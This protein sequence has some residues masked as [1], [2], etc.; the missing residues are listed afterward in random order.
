MQ[1]S[2]KRCI[3][4]TGTPINNNL[5]ELLA[6]LQFLMPEFFEGEGLEELHESCLR[7]HK[8]GSVSQDATAAGLVE[9]IR[10]LMSPFVLRRRKAD[11]LGE[12]V[13][14]VD[15]VHMIDIS[16]GQRAIYDGIVER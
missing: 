5:P 15:R 6:L 14:K 1:I 7:L 16:D 9:R 13:P 11:V 8:R 10:S 12:L 2:Y 3:L 4:L